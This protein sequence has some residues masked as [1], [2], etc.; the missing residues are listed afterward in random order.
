MKNILNSM[1]LFKKIG[2]LL[3]D[4]VYDEH[5]ETEEYSRRDSYIGLAKIN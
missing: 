4:S 1:N 3:Y 5:I 2:V